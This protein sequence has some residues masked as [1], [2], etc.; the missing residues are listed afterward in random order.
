[1]KAARAQLAANPRGAPPPLTLLFSMSEGTTKLLE[2]P[3]NEGWFVV[4]LDRIERGNAAGQKAV[5]DQQRATIG[6]SVGREYAEQFTQAVQ[7]K[8]GVKKNDKGIAALKAELGGA[9]SARLP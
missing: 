8:I 6:Q 2:A 7:A 9:A 5:I 3:N 4:H 1:M